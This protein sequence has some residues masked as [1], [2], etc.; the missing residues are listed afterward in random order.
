MR[1]SYRRRGG[2]KRWLFGILS[3]ALLSGGAYI[4]FS[5]DFERVA[6]QIEAPERITWNLRSPL[7]LKLRDNRAL[8]SYKVTLSDGEK[9]VV[10]GKGR[11]EGLRNEA[12]LKI[13]Y[14]QGKGYLEPKAKHL[15]LQV[16]LHDKSLWN[17]LM[18][19]KTTKRIDVDVDTRPPDV[20]ILSHSYAITQGGSAMA[21]LSVKDKAL[22]AVYVEAAGR[23]FEA[24]PYKKEGYYAVLFAW[25]FQAKHFR[26]EAVAIDAAGNKRRVYVPLYLKNRRYRVSYIAAKD[27]FIDG[28]IAE[29][30]SSEPAYAG[31][32][33]RL[34]RLRAV[35]EKMR[36]ANEARIHRYTQKVSKEP[37][38][39][40]RIQA[41][42]PLR[43]SVKVAS[44][45]DER[46]YYYKEKE[47]EVSL[48]YH[49]GYDLASTANAPIYA[50]NPG[51][52]VFADK[53]GI[54]GNMPIIDH[55]MGL[56]T[57]YG[58]CSKL[59]VEAGDEVKR[60]QVI[61]YTGKTGLAL[62][63]HLH[64]GVLVQGVEVR[65]VEWFDAKWIRTN[66]TDVLKEAEKKIG[67]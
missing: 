55:G 22:K 43:R 58:H 24:V 23:R 66:I 59:L 32:E 4:Y 53:N 44:F 31:I 17:F 6:P 52:V 9:R 2:A 60:D 47:N 63:D 26:A 10:I 5:P 19:N 50:S 13:A 30:A 28:K 56:Y 34:E 3:I 46:H 64:F 25:P 16:T 7:T 45:G 12:D 27:R 8:G 42:H 21:V 20:T 36:L 11:I 37:I 15:S 39:A 14:P 33:D 38:E 49:L 29:L 35:N 57:L 65:P 1:R 40:W 61:A 54:Y 18:G 62:G 41:F 51:K 67:D 48:S